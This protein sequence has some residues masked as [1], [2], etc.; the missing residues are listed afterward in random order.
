MEEL[1]QKQVYLRMNILEKGYDAE[2]FMN[3][4][5][6]KKGDLGLDLNNW[7][8]NELTSAVQEF[9]SLD[10]YINQNLNPEDQASQEQNNEND[11][12]MTII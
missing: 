9:M 1:Q 7:T 11:D 8:L 12:N 2:I 10:N 4:L 3:F 6:S 5:K